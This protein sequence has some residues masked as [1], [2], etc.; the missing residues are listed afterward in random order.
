MNTV[1]DRVTDVQD[2][3]IAAITSTKEPVSN[4]V[5]VVVAYVVDA[6]PSAQTH[7]VQAPSSAAPPPAPTPSAVPATP[8]AS[9][10]PKS[11]AG[12]A[13][14]HAPAANACSDPAR[15]FVVG[16]DGVR[17]LRRECR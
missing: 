3:V 4:A 2:Q 12:P 1:L 11:G 7:D 10:P 14:K 5:A 16:D 17:R 9:A 6:A 8:A 15:A 13:P